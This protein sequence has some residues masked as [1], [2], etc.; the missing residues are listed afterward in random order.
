MLKIIVLIRHEAEG[1]GQ[2]GKA[3]EVTL[4]F[5]T[6]FCF[7]APF[8]LSNFFREY[9]KINDPIGAEHQQ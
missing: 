4:L 2:E 7:F 1:R 3:F 6:Y 5:I 9:K 8:Y